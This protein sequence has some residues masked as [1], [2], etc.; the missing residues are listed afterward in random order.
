LARN[1]LKILLSRCIEPR[2]EKHLRK[3]IELFQNKGNDLSEELGGDFI[4]AS[5]RIGKAKTAAELILR[6]GYRIG[7]WIPYSPAIELFKTLST[8]APE[9]KKENHSKKEEKDTKDAPKTAEPVVEVTN[10]EL[11]INCFLTLVQK[12]PSL[13]TKESFTL[14]LEQA[15]SP[16]YYQ[17]IISFPSFYKLQGGEKEWFED[18]K[19][20]FPQPVEVVAPVP[21]ENSEVPVP[22]ENK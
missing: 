6:E 18:I 16:T 5:L 2:D 22:V 1:D 15:S 12:N 7:A 17:K 8:S 9:S 3:G 11:A 21:E 19:K 20:Q 4:A 10:P 13:A 14:L